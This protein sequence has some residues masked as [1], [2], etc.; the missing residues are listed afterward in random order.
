MEIYN[1]LPQTNCKKCGKDTCMAFALELLKGN[2]KIADCTPL[3]EEEKYSEKLKNL[4]NLIGDEEGK[5]KE[6]RINV[7]EEECDG[8]GICV[9]VCPVNARY[10][11]S[12]LSGKAPDF[13]PD[14]HQLFVVKGGKC[15]L[16]NLEHC[17]RVAAEGRER[18][19]R[20]CE[21]YCPREA[22]KIEY[23]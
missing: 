22:V 8:C 3:V 5:Q 2:V 12:T 4:K 7:D 1:F 21:T 23:V 10:C 13:P 14:E 16:L 6:L 17:R 11:Y 19:C 15:E 18:E 20:V 9:T